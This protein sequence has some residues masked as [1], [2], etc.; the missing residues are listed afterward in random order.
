MDEATYADLRAGSRRPWLPSSPWPTSAAAGR[1]PRP[2]ET[3]ARSSPRSGSTPSW[4]VAAGAAR[5]DLVDDP[6]V[7]G[8][9]RSEGEGA[10][11]SPGAWL[12][13]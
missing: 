6:V 3:L 9:I 4:V 1:W 10:V 7:L 5:D 2:P 8:L 11:G 13:T 12:G